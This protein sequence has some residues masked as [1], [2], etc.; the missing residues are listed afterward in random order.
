MSSENIVEFNNVYMTSDRGEPIFADVGLTLAAGRSVVISGPAGSGKTTLVE[1]LLGLR[2][3]DSGSV[4]LFGQCLRPR[5]GRL[6]KRIRRR[7]GG[8]G[9]VYDL[10]PSLTVAENV[11]FP[12]V[13]AAERKKVRRE[14]LMKVL[15]EF[16]LLKQASLYPRQLTRVEYTLAQ[17]ARA[18]I[19]N[20][21][22]L[23]I[24]EPSA[25]L[26]PAT[27]ERVFEYLV[28]VSVSGRSMI[29][30]TSHTEKSGLPQCD[31]WQI[32]DGRLS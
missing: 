12:L 8:V 9:G 19:A 3:P 5:K 20:Q 29:I 28:R 6:L 18:S 11:M 17:F 23:I 1:M 14:R 15:S 30:L 2:F 4:E 25:G 10:V 7:I 21:P 32:K 31:Y 26:D 24:D 13:L 22:L 27:Y 16:K